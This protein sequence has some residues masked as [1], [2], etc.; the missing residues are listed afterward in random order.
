MTAYIGIDPGANGGLAIRSDQYVEFKTMPKTEQEILG[1]LRCHIGWEEYLSGWR[2]LECRAHVEEIP[3]AIFGV[4]KSSMS[5]LYGSYMALRMAL[6]SLG[7]PYT[8]V[9]ATEWQRALG[10]SPRRKARKSRPL[11]IGQKP[12]TNAEWKQR[13][14][15]KAEELYPELKITLATSDALLILEYCRRRYE[16]GKG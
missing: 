2:M 10:I 11:P 14:K 3:T 9:K 16:N 13:L 7:I 4:G 5:K 15:R 1:W 12:E 8:T 6:T